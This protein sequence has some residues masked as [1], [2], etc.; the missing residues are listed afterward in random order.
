VSG[1]PEIECQ[2]CGVILVEDAAIHADEENQCPKCGEPLDEDD[3]DFSVHVDLCE[4]CG[5]IS[6]FSAEIC[7]DCWDLHYA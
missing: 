1:T 6:D 2:N 5:Q 4:M 3:I 7:Q